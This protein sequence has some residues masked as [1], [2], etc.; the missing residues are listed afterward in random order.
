M[1]HRIRLLC[2]KAAYISIYRYNS[3]LY[4]RRFINT[5]SGR[6]N[7]KSTREAKTETETKTKTKTKNEDNIDVDGDPNAILMDALQALE[8]LPPHRLKD[9]NAIKKVLKHYA[10]LTHAPHIIYDGFLNFFIRTCRTTPALFVMQRMEALGYTLLNQSVAKLLVLVAASAEYPPDDCARMIAEIVKEPEYTEEMLRD[11][12]VTIKSYGIDNERQAQTMFVE[13]FREV[14]EGYIPS[15]K[16]LPTFV[17]AAVR[18]GKFQDAHNMLAAYHSPS[19]SSQPHVERPARTQIFS[20]YLSLLK[21]LRETFSSDPKYAETYN[22]VLEQMSA[23]QVQVNGRLFEQVVKH[24]AALRDWDAAFRAY[25]ALRGVSKLEASVSD[26]QKL[27]RIS[28]ST[29]AT[30]F[31][32]YTDMGRNRAF[33]LDAANSTPRYKGMGIMS[34]RELF[35][36]FIRVFPTSKTSTTTASSSSS[37]RV[38]TS[39][40]LLH[41]ILRA[42]MAQVDYAGALVALRIF[43]ANGGANILTHQTYYIIVKAIVGRVWYEAG[44]GRPDAAEL[45]A[46]MKGQYGLGWRP[47]L[48]LMTK[49]KP[50]LRNAATWTSRFLGLPSAHVKPILGMRLVNHLLFLISRREWEVGRSVYPDRGKS[51]VWRDVK[52]DEE[53]VSKHESASS[54][55]PEAGKDTHKNEIVDG[56]SP[57]KPD[58]AESGPLCKV[59]TMH[60]M[61]HV[62]RPQPLDFKYELVPLERLLLRAIWA[63]D[64][65]GEAK[66]KAMMDGMAGEERVEQAVKKAERLMLGG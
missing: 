34:P 18:A 42:F 53:G 58:P 43:A 12:L 28:T 8:N 52:E 60:M 4:Y 32:M 5:T 36:D 3:N 6:D 11:L 17:G 38:Y 15:L 7:S 13:A 31:K 55:G 59:P 19:S 23:H 24:E 2:P 27:M 39:T 35:H 20:A 29:F 66:G 56:T 63:V 33:G 16:M 61:E 50:R 49:P 54:L 1:L 51:E 57:P 48:E 62:Q 30:L 46:G 26:E 22:K 21:A 40:P 45:V 47:G 41:V 25:G 65:I 64:G 44:S 14:R 10:A 9:I 37:S